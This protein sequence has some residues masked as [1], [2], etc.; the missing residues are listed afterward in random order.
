[1]KVIGAYYVLVKE[2]RVVMLQKHWFA[3]LT[4]NCSIITTGCLISGGRILYTSGWCISGPNAS[5]VFS[6]TLQS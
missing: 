4:L 1:M 2:W 6:V 3:T 5:V